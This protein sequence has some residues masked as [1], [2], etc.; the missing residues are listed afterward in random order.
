MYKPVSPKADFPALEHEILRFWDEHS[1]FQQLVERNRGNARYSFIDGPITANNPMGVHHAWGRTYKDVYQ[2]FWAMRGRD[3]RYQNGFDCQ[4]LWVEVEVERALGL[5][6]KRQIEAYGLDKFAERCR[7]RVLQYAGVITEQSIRLGQWMDWDHSYYTMSDNNI[8]H[9][10]HFLKR[11]QERGWLYKGWRT[12]PWCTRCGT[13]LSQHELIGTDSYRE[14]SHPSLYVKLPIVDRP[15]EFFMVWTTTPWTLPANVALA[16]HPDLDY[17]KAVVGGEAYYLSP[18]TLGAVFGRPIEIDATAGGDPFRAYTY[19]ATTPPEVV[20][21]VKGRDLVGWRYHGPFDEL[22]AQRD[23]QHAVIPWEEVGEEEGTGIVHIAP[24]CGAEDFALGQRFGLPVLVP[25]DDN[26]DFVPGYGPLVGANVHDVRDAVFASLQEKGYLHRVAEI[27]HRYPTCWRCGEEIVFRGVS[28]WF[29]SAEEI[30][31]RM[32][33]A[34]RTVAWTPPSAGK[35]MEDW[36]NNMQ[37][38]CISRKRYWGLPLPF[39]PCAACDTLTVVGSVEELRSRAVTGMDQVRELHRPWIDAVRI[40]CPSCGAEVERVTEVGDC[41]LDAGIVPFSTLGPGYLK[42]RATWAS[43]FPADWVSEMREQIRLWFYSMLFMSVALED[44]S[45]YQAVLVYEKLMDETGQPMHKSLGNAIWFEEAA[46]RMGADVMRWLY[47]GQNLTTNLLFGYGPAEEVRRKLLVLWNVYSFFVTY[48]EVEEFTPGHGGAGGADRGRMDRWILSRLDALVALANDRLEAYD[49]AAVV[50]AVDR[51]V[52]DLSTWY[53]RRSRRRFSRAA[54]P[55]DRRA[56]FSTLH[57]CLVDLARVIAPIMPF[58]AEE[59]YQNLVRSWDSAAPQ[60]VHLTPYPTTDGARRAPELDSEMEL[61]R[62]VV[63]L[64]RAARGEAGIRVRQP[65]PSITIAGESTDLQLSDELRR[66]IAD[67]LNVKAVL[68]AE[69]VEAFA[70]RTARP[71]PRVLGPKLGHDFPAVSRAL[72]AGDYTIRPDGSVA[73]RGVV[74]EPGEVT[75]ALEPLENRA[76]AQD[77]R[78]RGGL[79]VALDRT[80]TPE[81]RNEGR[82]RELVH[83]VQTMRRDAGLSVDDRITLTFAGSESWAAV[84]REHRDRI[85]DE[86]G[87]TDLRIGAP[88]GSGATLTWKGRLD[89]EE[90]ELAL[91]RTGD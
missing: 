41:W 38:W 45:P 44:R 58:L 48:A 82:A 37:D 78:F 30:R 64:G 23:V 7:E 39:Y 51:F 86:V 53:L 80:V 49:V 29:I 14:V 36:L 21:T 40:R 76:V 3:Q 65:L 27:Q 52:D 71:N 2:R 22:D 59:M 35:R 31:P 56:A 6:S 8:E 26:G 85:L 67:E 25:I 46:E 33:A 10:W 89:D 55:A 88:D 61:A 32:I 15:G 54:E 84:V 73:V 70:R 69:N 83:R 90:I 20:A 18:K 5:N 16:V 24:G 42:D 62:E 66:E 47:A 57:T 81:L 87:A 74:L 43:W 68:T 77:L 75:I 19:R 13:S 91:R 4:G 11:C 12:M 63:T 28:E 9:I 72:Q 50:D 17:V 79:A 1:V 34:A 60:S